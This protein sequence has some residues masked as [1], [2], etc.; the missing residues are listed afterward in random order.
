MTHVYTVT[1]HP[2]QDG[3]WLASA[4]HHDRRVALAELAVDSVSGDDQVLL[5]LPAGFLRAANEEARDRLAEAMLQLSRRAHVALLFGIDVA[6]EGRWAPLAGADASFAYACES[7]RRVLWPATQL[8]PS[9]KRLP[10]KPPENRCVELVGSRVGVLVSSEAFSTPLRL[11]FHG[12]EPDLIV[13]LAHAPPTDR[14]SGAVASWQC[15]APTFVVAPS[16][17]GS[18]RHMPPWILAAPRRWQVDRVAETVDMTIRRYSK[19]CPVCDLTEAQQ[20]AE[21]AAR[22]IE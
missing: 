18:A 21:A 13:V 17:P 3:S 14:W 1:F 4:R 2:P 5:A 11:A 16:A 22:A 12:T 19:D 6:D 20:A 8:K 15:I 7:G 10:G 9:R